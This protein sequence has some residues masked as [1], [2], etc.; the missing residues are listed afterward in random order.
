MFEMWDTFANMSGSIF[1]L[2]KKKCLVFFWAELIQKDGTSHIGNY[3]N[4]KLLN[5]LYLDY[6]NQHSRLEPHLII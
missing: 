6:T 4:L 2:D 5:E 1:H 3:L